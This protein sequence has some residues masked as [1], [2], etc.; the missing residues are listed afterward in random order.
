MDLY[1][2]F[3]IGASRSLDR[4]R[5]NLDHSI[6]DGD[7]LSGALKDLEE[8]LKVVSRAATETENMLAD[9]SAA[10]DHASDLKAM[11]EVLDRRWEM[12]K[13][14]VSALY[15]SVSLGLTAE[16][17]A[18]EIHNIADRLARRSSALLRQVKTGMRE[19]P[20]I[21]YV[22]HVRSSIAAMRKQL[23]HLTPSLRYL[24]ERR[25]RI[26][27]SGW[28]QELAAFHNRRLKEKSIEVVVVQQGFGDLIV[29]INKGK[30]TQIVDKLDTQRRVLATRSDPCG[31]VREWQDYHHYRRAGRASGG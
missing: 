21:A 14:E 10:L 18:H 4:V 16:V 19:A 9:V 13:E 15:E 23:A 28:A 30:L 17:L 5:K 8:Q 7:S 11:R 27:V 29:N 24:R 31:L 22:E 26:D 2:T 6:T 3:A 20:I 1:K 25:E 12:F